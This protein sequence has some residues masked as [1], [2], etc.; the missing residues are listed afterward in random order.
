MTPILAFEH[1]IV[2]A[3]LAATAVACDGPLASFVVAN[4]TVASTSA[5][6]TARAA[7]AFFMKYPSLWMNPNPFDDQYAHLLQ[8]GLS[9]WHAR[10]DRPR[11]GTRRGHGAAC[12]RRSRANVRATAASG[13]T[14]RARSASTR[15]R[16]GAG[17]P[18]PPARRRPRRRCDCASRRGPAG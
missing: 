4:A 11:D 6:T 13:C 10:P 17:R 18:R 3:A 8:L 5:T 14:S 1:E 2:L 15:R 16:P 12:R 7:I 9:P